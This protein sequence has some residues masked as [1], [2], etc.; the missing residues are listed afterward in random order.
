MY[1]NR[2]RNAIQF[3]SE[4]SRVNNDTVQQRAMVPQI[5]SIDIKNIGDSMTGPLNRKSDYWH[6]ALDWNRGQ[7]TIHCGRVAR[8]SAS[9]N[10]LV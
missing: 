9:L 3:H 2:I 6:M 1:R 4:S 10:L 5:D 7:E 8:S